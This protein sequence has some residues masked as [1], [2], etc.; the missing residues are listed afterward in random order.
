MTGIKILWQQETGNRNC[1]ILLA[2]DRQP[3][4]DKAQG[5]KDSTDFKKKKTKNRVGGGVGR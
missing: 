5:M 4:P 3:L 2:T 1:I